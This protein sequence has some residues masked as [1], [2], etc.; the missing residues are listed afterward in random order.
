MLK[1]P[2]LLK[3]LSILLVLSVI[4]SCSNTKGWVYKT[5]SYDKNNHSNMNNKT[6]AVLPFSDK[7]SN[8]NK[9]YYM[10]YAL[11]LSPFGYQN[12]SS[13][14]TVQMH[15][16]SGLWIN[17]NPKEDFAKALVEELNAS[18]AFREVFFS[19]STRDSE[20]YISG[21]IVSTDYNAKLFSYGLSI[22]GPLLWYFGLPATHVANDLEVKLS[23]M[24]SKTRKEVFTKNYRADHYGKTGWIYSLPS[25]FRYSEM[26]ASIYKRFS[27]DLLNR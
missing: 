6:V 18:G 5:N 20:Y 13:P 19:T 9:N 11:P 1:K 21:E 12:L 14:E 25:D 3:K 17:F 10:L 15:A 26:L 22:Y 4:T 8:E 27:E 2:Q 24:N 16:N 23:L 7:R